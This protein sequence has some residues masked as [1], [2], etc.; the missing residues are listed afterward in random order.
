MAL[1][2]Y[3]GYPLIVTE[4][5]ILMPE[6]WWGY[7][8][9]DVNAFMDAT[10][11]FL[12][13]TTDPGLGDPDDGGRLVQRWAWFSLDNPPYDQA[14]PQPQT[15]NGNLFDPYTTDITG[16]GLNFGT[17]TIGFPP[18]DHVELR[19]GGLRFEPL[20]PVASGEM[21][22]RMV[23]VEVQ[24]LG[25]Q[26]SGAFA[27]RLAYD[28]PTSGQL[29]RSVSNLVSGSSAWISLEL[30]QLSQ[31]AYSISMWVD[32][33]NVVFETTECDNQLESIMVVPAD[34]AYLPLIAR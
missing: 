32:P 26:D 21:V 19:P 34:L 8:A 15:F 25:S 16:Y 1:N 24:N 14:N 11:Q 3:G 18:L 33:D 6:G 9:D 20:G 28:G 10:F 5:G 13:Q 30:T 2:D 12:S 23:E 4:F 31:G 7:D 17:N 27:V 29:Q 22:N